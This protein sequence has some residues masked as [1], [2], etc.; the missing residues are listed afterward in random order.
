MLDKS[1]GKV[2]CDEFINCNSWIQYNNDDI[3][4]ITNY[5]NMS[6]GVWNNNGWSSTVINVKNVKSAC[7]EI[8]NGG[9]LNNEK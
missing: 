6:F 2:W 3:I 9:K 8:M 5:I 4:S 7:E 1:T